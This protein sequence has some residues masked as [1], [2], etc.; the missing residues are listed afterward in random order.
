[1]WC[2]LFTSAALASCVSLAQDARP[3]LRP[4]D[5]CPVTRPP[6][7][8]F[9]APAG[10]PNLGDSAWFLFGTEKLWTKL[11]ASG[12]YVTIQ[13]A[14]GYF[15]KHVWWST[16]YDWH[17][18]PRP[19]LA[20]TA[21]RLDSSTV[22]PPPIRG[23]PSFTTDLGSFYMSGPTFPSKGCWEVTGQLGLEKLAFV[24]WVVD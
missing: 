12:V 5:T 6:A 8:V 11:P 14:D 10:Y 17:A 20:I 9:S 13:H 16:S 3:Y 22:S 7:E 23:N 2:K 19:E 18:G 4:P 21:R 1:M 15:N 24:V